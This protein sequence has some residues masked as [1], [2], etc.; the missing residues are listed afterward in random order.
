MLILKE[1]FARLSLAGLIS[2]GIG[3]I[4]ISIRR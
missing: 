4:M 1:K 3:I 2:V